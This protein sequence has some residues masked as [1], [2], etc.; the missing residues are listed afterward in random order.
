ME[1]ALATLSGVRRQSGWLPYCLTRP[2]V[3]ASTGARLDADPRL[4]SQCQAPPA[5]RRPDPLAAVWDA[6]VPML[7]STPGLRPVAVFE[8]MLR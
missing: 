1:R 2:G 6:D 5:R 4:P 3:G 7:Q 8:E